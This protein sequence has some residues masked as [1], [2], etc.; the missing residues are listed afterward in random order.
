MIGFGDVALMDTPRG[1]DRSLPS[2]GVGEKQK[3]YADKLDRCMSFHEIFLLVKKS[4]KEVLNLERTGLILYLKDL[5]LKVG[6]YHPVG[7]NGVIMNRTL[8]EHVAQAASSRVLVNSFIYYIL[9]HEYLHTL[10]YIDERY[11]R[12]LVHRVSEEVFGSGHMATRIAA[13]GPWSIIKINPFYV[14]RPIER[15]VQ[16]VKDFEEPSFRYIS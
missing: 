15:K 2:T 12:K 5:P 14:P 6:A 9:L 16:I 3:E 8:L 7:T 11:V 1:L 10:G 13:E 4:V